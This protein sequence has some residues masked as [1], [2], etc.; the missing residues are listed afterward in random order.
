MLA[1]SRRRTPLPPDR[2]RQLLL[3]AATWVFA[4]KGYRAAAV[5]DIILRAEVARGTFYL[6]FASK[7]AVFLA[8][9]QAFHDRIRQ[10]LQA[11]DAAPPGDAAG[12][13]ARLRDGVAR[14]LR[15]FA[16]HRDE[17]RVILR[18]ASSIDPRFEKGYAELRQTAVSHFAARYRR[19]QAARLVRGTLS[20]DLLAHLLLGMF[21]ELLNAFVLS[22]P[23]A[24][25]EALAAELADFE[26]NGIAPDVED[27]T[28]GPERTAP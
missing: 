20:P 8:V 5:S 15:F 26:W 18:E 27:R 7:Q 10:E 13:K 16:E 14:W 28:R 22:D 4:R 12:L 2:R 17:T 19:L 21:D 24:D 1:M 25:I 23:A 6:Y 11:M 9:V 3:E